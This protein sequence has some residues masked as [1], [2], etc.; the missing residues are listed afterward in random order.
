MHG[1]HP[2]IKRVNQ[3]EGANTV[4]E[5]SVAISLYPYAQTSIMQCKML[6]ALVIVQKSSTKKEAKQISLQRYL[7]DTN[8]III[9]NQN[10]CTV[11]VDEAKLV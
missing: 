9:Y 6:P 8:V 1:F 4:S 7:K 2:G 5:A 10:P 11:N 3:G